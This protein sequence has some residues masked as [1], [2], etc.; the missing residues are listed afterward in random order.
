MLFEVCVIKFF[1]FCSQILKI[2]LAEGI[3]L[4]FLR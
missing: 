1:E 3:Q 2:Q 4:V